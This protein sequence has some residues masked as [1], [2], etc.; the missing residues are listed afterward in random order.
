MCEDVRSGTDMWGCKEEPVC[1][2]CGKKVFVQ[3]EEKINKHIW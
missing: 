1:E 3:D 2:V